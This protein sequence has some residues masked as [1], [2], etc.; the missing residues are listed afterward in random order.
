[1]DILWVWYIEKKTADSA[2]AADLYSKDNIVGH[3]E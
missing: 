3:I 1:M 2:T